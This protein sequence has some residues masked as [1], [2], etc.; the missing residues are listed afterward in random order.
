MQMKGS[1]KAVFFFIF[2]FWFFCLGFCFVLFLCF[3]F[4]DRVQRQFLKPSLTAFCIDVDQR[5]NSQMA[6]SLFQ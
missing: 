4:G 5:K 6:Y 2:F 1:S 3:V